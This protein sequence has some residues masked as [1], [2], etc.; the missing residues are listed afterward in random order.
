MGFDQKRAAEGIFKNSGGFQ[1]L[2][3]IK[4]YNNINRVIVGVKKFKGYGKISD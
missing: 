3:V 1:I 4:D 2:K